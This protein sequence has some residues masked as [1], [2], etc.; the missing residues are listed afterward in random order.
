MQGPDGPQ[1]Q[2]HTASS[3]RQP[4]SLGSVPRMPGPIG[5]M[6]R[7]WAPLKVPAAAGFMT[8]PPKKLSA[9]AQDHA[10]HRAGDGQ[11]P[12]PPQ[13]QGSAANGAGDALH[14]PE[15]HKGGPR[16]SPAHKQLAF[17]LHWLNSAIPTGKAPLY[18]SARVPKHCLP[19]MRTARRRVHCAVGQRQRLLGAALR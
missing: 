16:A 18:S 2:K 13:Q 19:C 17:S 9:A 5:S 1:Q 8:R 10:A 4:I 3:M 14:Q 6:G 12:A 7:E 15:G 11:A